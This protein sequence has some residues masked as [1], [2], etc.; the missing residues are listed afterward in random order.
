MNLPPA[1]LRNSSQPSQSSASPACPCERRPEIEVKLA[2]VGGIIVRVLAVVVSSSSTRR[3]SGRLTQPSFRCWMAL[4]PSGPHPPPSEGVCC[5]CAL[6]SRATTAMA[7][8]SGEQRNSLR[9][10]STLSTLS[11]E[12]P[13]PS[14]VHDGRRGEEVQRVESSESGGTTAQQHHEPRS[15]LTS[16]RICYARP[17]TPAPS[18]TTAHNN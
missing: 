8:E 18:R 15:A 11:S 7:R 3:F 17:P 13:N 14:S 12:R 5:C 16:G 1:Q 6:T 4:C 10:T 2:V 9:I